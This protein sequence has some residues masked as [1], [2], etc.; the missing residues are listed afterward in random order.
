MKPSKK[1]RTVVR[2]KH[3]FDEFFAVQRIKIK[4]KI[5]WTLELIEDL[6][7][8]PERYLKHLTN[9][10]GLYEVRVRHG[11]DIFRII[12]F[13]DA[14]KL[15]IL[16]NGFQKKTQRTPK[17]IIDQARRIKIEYEREKSK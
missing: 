16:M 17:K 6:E 8:V 7:Q 5:I 13:F 15:V 9:T 14:E 2:Y 12:C 4:E 11:T 10:D 3:Y 1:Y